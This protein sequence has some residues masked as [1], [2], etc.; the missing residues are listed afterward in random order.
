MKQLFQQLH[1]N[2]TLPEDLEKQILNSY[3]TI[4]LIMDVTDLFTS[5]FGK[6]EIE[7]HLNIEE[8]I[9]KTSKLEDKSND[10]VA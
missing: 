2:H 10:N 4:K 5:K 6:S 1:Q 3:D 9:R 8:A 7:M